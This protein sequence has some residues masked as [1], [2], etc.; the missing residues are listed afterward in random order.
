MNSVHMNH[1]VVIGGQNEANIKNNNKNQNRFSLLTIIKWRLLGLHKLK[2]NMY[3]P[4]GYTGKNSKLFRV[5]VEN[6]N[7]S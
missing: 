4:E 7:E 3:L 5:E 6:E 1:L 2:S